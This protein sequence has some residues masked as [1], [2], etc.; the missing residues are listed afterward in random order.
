MK[1]EYITGAGR[2]TLQ[3][4]IKQL[5]NLMDDSASHIDANEGLANQIWLD[6][7]EAL[8]IAAEAVE[9]QIPKKPVKDKEARYGMG[10]EYH[11][12]CCPTCH[13]FLSFEPS[14]AVTIHH[15]KCG[16]ALDWGLVE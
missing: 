5:K 15:C 2:M 3:K 1:T 16:Q 7:V 11:D 13:G 6:D 12:W 14:P 10:Y 9:K 8:Q 4:A